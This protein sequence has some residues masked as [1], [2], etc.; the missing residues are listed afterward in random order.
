MLM[1]RVFMVRVLMVGALRVGRDAAAVRLL[2]RLKFSSSIS[3]LDKPV[4]SLLLKGMI[5]RGMMLR[6]LNYTLE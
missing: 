2:R 5:D 4:I 1:V 6:L 3:F